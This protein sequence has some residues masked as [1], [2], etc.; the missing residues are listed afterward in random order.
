MLQPAASARARS[1]SEWALALVTVLSGCGAAPPEATTSAG[2]EGEVAVCSAA[3]FDDLARRLR[4]YFCNTVEGSIAASEIESCDDIQVTMRAPARVG[5]ALDARVLELATSTGRVFLLMACTAEHTEAFFLDDLWNTTDEEQVATTAGTV[6]H[7]DLVPRG[8][9]ELR[10]DMVFSEARDARNRCSF[11]RRRT[12]RTILCE[13]AASGPRCADVPTL[14]R[15]HAEC[16]EYCLHQMA[17][18]EPPTCEN[19]GGPTYDEASHLAL[20]LEDGRVRVT[21]IPLADA[22]TE[23][24]EA[25]A[26]LVGE[27]TFEELL[28]IRPLEPIDLAMLGD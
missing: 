18:E 14:I 28:L 16:E 21:P 8:A 24:L 1:R 22:S 5:G 27:H 11:V 15:N 9:V 19:D 2:G 4:D 23:A 12:E 7:F 10:L 20:N 25:P 13:A 26:G 3:S 17:A 6:S